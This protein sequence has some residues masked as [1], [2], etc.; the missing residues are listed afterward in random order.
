MAGL[1][2]RERTGEGQHVRTSLLQSSTSFIAENMARFLEERKAPPTRDTRT[3]TAQVYAFRDRAGA[4]FVIH[5]SSP[6]KFWQGLAR[7]VGHPELIDDRRFANRKA[8]IEHH[9]DI[10]ELLDGIFATDTREQWL[11]RLQAEDV[12]SA[13]MYTFGEVVEDPQVRHLGLIQETTHPKMGAM[14]MVG[15]GITLEST[16]TV[17]GPAPVLGEHTEEILAELGLPAEWSATMR[18]NA[19]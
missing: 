14:P 2:A 18:A 16:P 10:Q 6:D 9:D 4:P 8:R 5:L 19:R 7:A 13:A 15:S 11:H 17:M 1:A 3:R 12:P